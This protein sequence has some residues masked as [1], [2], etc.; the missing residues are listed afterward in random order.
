MAMASV[1]PPLKVFDVSRLLEE[2]S[3]ES[4][5]EAR[6]DLDVDCELNS[7]PPI[8]CWSI[9]EATAVL[10]RPGERLK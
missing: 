1:L 9:A 5:F 8:L 3:F 10:V 7:L 4:S 6:S 2:D